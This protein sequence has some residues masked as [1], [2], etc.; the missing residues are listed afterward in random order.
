[1]LEV[2][3]R[4]YEE[5]LAIPVVAGVK[6]ESERFAGAQD[7]YSVEALMQDGRAL[8]A[9]T[10][11]FLGQHFAKVFDITFLDRDGQRK[12]GWQTSWGVSTRSIGAIV[13]VHG[14]DAGLM[15]P[16]KIAPIQV[17]IVPI[18][19]NDA[20]KKAVYEMV[21]EIEAALHEH[22]RVHVDR[23]EEQTPGW[24]Y[25]EWELRG[26]PVR[27]EIGPRDVKQEK[28]VLVRRDTLA[29]TMY[30]RLPKGK[31]GWTLSDGGTAATG[32]IVHAAVENQEL[33]VDP[34]LT[35]PNAAISTRIA[36][37]LAE[38]Y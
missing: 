27:L 19:K 23:R 5:D 35:A 26:V 20:E 34:D 1:M 6:S 9:G 24:K 2:Y 16:P 36:V 8:Q 22:V 21:D 13:M 12:H 31:Q 32:R 10:S 4:F 38:D 29:E 28:V 25:N 33:L 15:L 37:T 17:V 7:T 3:R 11:H 30:R 18:Y 14:D